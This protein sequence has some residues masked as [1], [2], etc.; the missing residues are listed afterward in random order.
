LDERRIR[1]GIFSS[2]SGVRN[3]DLG[4]IWALGLV[5]SKDVNGGVLVFIFDDAGSA[6]L[7]EARVKDTILTPLSLMRS[8]RSMLQK[9]KD[10]HYNIKYL[11]YG[12]KPYRG[13]GQMCLESTAG[14]V[15][16]FV[17]MVNH[18]NGFNVE[19]LESFGLKEIPCWSRKPV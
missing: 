10:K 5:G 16:G 13:M 17:G 2:R 14:F 11:Y 6:G 18:A 12:G 19:M 8:Q 3:S 1:V 7:E 15:E 4:H 9:L